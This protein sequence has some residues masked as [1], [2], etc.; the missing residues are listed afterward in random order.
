MVKEGKIPFLPRW[1]ERKTSDSLARVEGMDNGQLFY[2]SIEFLSSENVVLRPSRPPAD[3]YLELVLIMTYR[4]GSGAKRWPAF[5][6]DEE[7]PCLCILSQATTTRGSGW[8]TWYLALAPWGYAWSIAFFF[9]LI[10]RRDE[11]S[12]ILRFFPHALKYLAVANL[13][14]SDLIIRDAEI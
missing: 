2:C 5:R 6:I 9:R 4:P 1:G 12:Y 14:F 8:E 3:R 13:L 11:P 7:D 10:N